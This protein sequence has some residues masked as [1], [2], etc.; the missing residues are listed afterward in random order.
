MAGKEGIPELGAEQHFVD[1]AKRLESA[2]RETQAAQIREAY[3][4]KELYQAERDWALEILR[5]RGIAACD[6][7]SHWEFAHLRENVTEQAVAG[8]FPLEDL[9]IIYRSFPTDFTVGVEGIKRKSFIKI[10]ETDLANIYGGYVKIVPDAEGRYII[11]GEDLSQDVADTF[12]DI[13]ITSSRMSY[14]GLPG[15]P[16][17]GSGV[18]WRLRGGNVNTKINDPFYDSVARKWIF[19]EIED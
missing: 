15:I 13:T 18:G 4:L 10:C 16:R 7:E 5:E 9:S 1:L 6:G 3:V 19:P 11:D 14:L 8:I 17:E 12:N 2:W